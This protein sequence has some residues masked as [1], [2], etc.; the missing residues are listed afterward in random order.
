MYTFFNLIHQQLGLEVEIF[1]ELEH[2]LKSK[3]YFTHKT[4]GM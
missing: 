2:A 3:G 4:K 1:I